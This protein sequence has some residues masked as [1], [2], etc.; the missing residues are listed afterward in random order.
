M[1]LNRPKPLII[2]VYTPIRGILFLY[3]FLTQKY[4]TFAFDVKLKINY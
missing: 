2:M 4:F 1:R 3:L